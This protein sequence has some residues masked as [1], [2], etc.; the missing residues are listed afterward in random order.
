VTGPRHAIDD[1]YLIALARAAR[2]EALVSG[3]QHLLR[4]RGE[5]PVLTAREYVGSLQHRRR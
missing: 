2:V 3:D 4:L 5:I 1:E